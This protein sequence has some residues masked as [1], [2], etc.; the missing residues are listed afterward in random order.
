MFSIEPV[1]DETCLQFKMKKQYIKTWKIS[2]KH[3]S[4]SPEHR[5]IHEGECLWLCN[6]LLS[7]FEDT[8]QDYFLNR[9]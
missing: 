5:I 2:H 6:I 3:S 1:K 4:Y 8:E 9:L 7:Q